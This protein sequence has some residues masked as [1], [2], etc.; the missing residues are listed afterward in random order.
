MNLTQVS[1]QEEISTFFK[2]DDL[3][4]NLF[5]LKSLPEDLVNCNL[6]IKSDLRLAGLP[7]FNA[8]FA[9]LGEEQFG[10]DAIKEFEGKSLSKGAVIPLGKLPFAKAL[11]GERIALNLLQ[12]ASNIATYTQQFVEKAEKYKIKIL[13]TRKTTPGLRSLEKYAVRVGG[14]FNHRLGQTDVWMVKDNHKTFF[15][16]VKEAIQFFESMGSFYNP[17]ELEV[18]DE[19]E[20]DLAI[21]MGISHVMLDNFSP[22]RIRAVV[23]RKPAS[24]TIEVSGGVTHNNINDYLIGG[25]DAISIGSLTYAAPAVDISFKYQKS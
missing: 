4:R 14:G 17:I 23:R 12:R 21:E 5:Y 20:F 16:G 9:H 7:W 1:L 15:G 10:L 24:M 25:V 11:T 18:H 3:S 6:F 13:D 2:E 19:K 22:D 8:T